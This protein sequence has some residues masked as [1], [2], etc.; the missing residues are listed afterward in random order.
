MF[1]YGIL[2][3][4][5]LIYFSIKTKDITRYIKINYPDIY[6]KRKSLRMTMQ[7]DYAV[8]FF[9]LTE[10]EINTFA[11]KKIAGNIRETK[12]LLRDTA[13]AYIVIIIISLSKQYFTNH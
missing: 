1:V 2:A 3:T 10:V 11:E 4:L 6:K 13:V 9:K 8:N 7:R 5:L 12:T